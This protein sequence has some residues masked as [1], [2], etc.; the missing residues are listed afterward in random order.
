MK[1]RITLAFGLTATQGV[2]LAA[3]Y[4]LPPPPNPV[5]AA[6]PFLG[7]YVALGGSYGING[8]RS[9]SVS[10][11]EPNLGANGPFS[12][13]ANP[14]GWSGVA[15]AGYNMAFGPAVISL[16][17]DGRLGSEKFR[18]DGAFL[19]GGQVAYS[20]ESN[21]DAAVHLAARAGAVIANTLIFAKAGIGVS[22]INDTFGVD[23]TGARR[24]SSITVLST[25]V[26]PVSGGA[27]THVMARWFPTV[28]LGVGAEQNFGAFFARLA[29]ETET[30][31]QN[32]YSFTG[33]PTADGWSFS[34]SPTRRVFGKIDSA[35]DQ[36]L[37]VEARRIEPARTSRRLR[38][39]GL[40]RYFA[41]G[42]GAQTLHQ[43][44]A[45]TSLPGKRLHGRHSSPSLPVSCTQ[46][47]QSLPG[48]N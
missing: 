23:Q 35:I 37:A 11:S 22:R 32:T 12:N 4:G 38:R 42:F 27:A 31:P 34:G 36:P 28:V 44:L 10:S 18:N 29:A 19:S 17:V 39:N 47:A 7:G 5:I 13:S 15:A 46:F 33:Q 30:L 16:E 45:F 6:N 24:C 20:F 14:A 41:P 1:Q 21:S 2:A 8:Q 48:L 3:D 43:P 25:C 26:S 9:Y 40:E